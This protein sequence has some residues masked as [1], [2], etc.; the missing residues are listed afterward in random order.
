ME[1]NVGKDQR[2]NPAISVLF[3]LA[4]LDGRISAG[5]GL[6]SPYYLA[7]LKGGQG[8]GDVPDYEYVD[9]VEEGTALFEIVGVPI[10]GVLSVLVPFL[11]YPGTG[12]EGLLGAAVKV[13]LAHALQCSGI[14]LHVIGSGDIPLQE[15][16]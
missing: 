4:H 12:A 13:V 15:S 2:A 9:S 16:H 1:A 14:D 8:P 3:H 11:E 7:G 5:H 10:I 6:V